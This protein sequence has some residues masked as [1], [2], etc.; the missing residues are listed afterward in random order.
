[1]MCLFVC[2]VIATSGIDYDVFVCLF[3]CLV[4]AT[5]GIDYDVFV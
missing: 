2:L 4:I 3:V 5:S 1:M